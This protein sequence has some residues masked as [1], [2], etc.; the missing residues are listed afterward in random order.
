MTKN[1]RK[2]LLRLFE[3]TEQVLMIVEQ[4]KYTRR[5]NEGVTCGVRMACKRLGISD[6]ALYEIWHDVR[7]DLT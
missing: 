4:P 1:E 7:W 5:F 6:A 2:S 3:E